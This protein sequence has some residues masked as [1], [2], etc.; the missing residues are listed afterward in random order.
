MDLELT[1]EM[2]VGASAWTMKRYP[3]NRAIGAGCHSSTG[4]NELAN[5]RRRCHAV[6]T[7]VDVKYL[8]SISRD[9]GCDS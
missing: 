2:S 7:R 4:R 8:I 5:E 1:R 9:R 3:G 6:K